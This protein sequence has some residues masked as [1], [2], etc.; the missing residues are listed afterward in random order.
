LAAEISRGWLA[1]VDLDPAVSIAPYFS[2]LSLVSGSR[3]FISFLLT[4]PDKSWRLSND[5][6]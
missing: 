3:L 1:I 5:Q 6:K 2:G 4:E